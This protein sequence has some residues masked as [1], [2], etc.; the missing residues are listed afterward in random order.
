MALRV[1]FVD[2]CILLT[3]LCSLLYHTRVFSDKSPFLA[4]YSMLIGNVQSLDCFTALTIELYKRLPTS[5]LIFFPSHS[6][7]IEGC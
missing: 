2:I 3:M 1:A 5:I 4:A 6:I 7:R